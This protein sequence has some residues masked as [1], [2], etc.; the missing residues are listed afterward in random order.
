[1][2]WANGAGVTHE[3]RRG[4]DDAAGDF[5]WRISF[6]EVTEPGPF[7]A[8]PGVDRVITLVCG[9]S[10]RLSGS[11][12][13]ASIEHTLRVGE[14][15]SFRGEADIHGEPEGDTIDLN[16]MTRRGRF[17]GDVGVQ[18]LDGRHASAVEGPTDGQTRYLAVL[19]GGAAVLGGETLA[20]LDVA[21]IDEPCAVTGDAI[22]AVITVTPA[23]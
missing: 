11:D 22:L 21:E 5:G 2:P 17:T 4:G 7:S 20:P 13:T 8:L 6:A 16:L 1:M 12:G 9:K 15:W 3:V 10:L 18:R 14:P 19:Q 23:D